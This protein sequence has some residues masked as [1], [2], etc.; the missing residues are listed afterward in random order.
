[1][2]KM[3]FILLATLLVA[4]VKAEVMQIWNSGQIVYQQSI[5]S[6]DSLTFVNEGNIPTPSKLCKTWTGKSEI[7]I[8]L[9]LTK[10]HTFTFKCGNEEYG[11]CSGEY[12][13]QG[14]M[15]IL[16][17]TSGY[18]ISNLPTCVAY[19]KGKLYSC[20]GGLGQIVFE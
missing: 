12:L 8:K 19:N 9:T 16:C 13:V 1:M 17:A 10:R 18:G 3:F 4:A 7:L 5:E 6:M 14:N 2:K 15:I 20:V 11:T